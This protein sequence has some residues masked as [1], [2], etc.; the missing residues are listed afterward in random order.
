[1]RRIFL[2]A[3][4]LAVAAGS[5]TPSLP[6]GASN[7]EEGRKVL[8]GTVSSTPAQ[9]LGRGPSG[10]VDLNPDT[11]RCLLAFS[12]E[13]TYS[14][15]MVGQDTDA[16]SLSLQLSTLSGD[17]VALATFR[18]TVRGCPSPGTAT[19]RVVGRIGVTPGR[20]I[21]TVEVIDGAGSG[22]LARLQGSGQ[23]ESTVHADGTVTGTEDLIVS[24]AKE[25]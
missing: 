17:V 24:C 21:G 22:G 14:G 13:D 23:F 15:D 2:I 16:G 3:S 19:L 20:D 1:V 25:H 10:C 6:A 11:G 8:H 18:G 9:L 7:S 4:A 5:V 12:Q